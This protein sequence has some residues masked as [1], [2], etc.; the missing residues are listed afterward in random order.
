MFDQVFIQVTSGNGGSGTISGRR[1]KF[2]PAGGPDGGDGGRGG[3]VYMTT[4]NNVTTLLEFR[5]RRRFVAGSGGHGAGALKH[6]EAGRDVTIV[7]PVGTEV[8]REGTRPRVLFD[9]ANPGQRVRVATGGEGGR[10]NAKF[11]SSTTRYPMLAE[12]GERGETIKLRLELKLLADVA[13]MGAPNAGKSSLLAAVSA[14]RPKI[15][16]YPFTTLE[17]FLGVV[18]H[19]GHRFV[20]VDV[21]GLI[22]GAHEGAGLGHDFLR[23]IERTRV[24]VHV[25]DGSAEDPAQQY[26]EIRR[27]VRAY[28]GSDAE[29]PGVVAVNKIDL[30][31][32]AERASG[33]KSDL[34]T[35]G[36]EVCFISAI[37][38]EGVGPL[39]DRV[40]SILERTASSGNGAG[41][42]DGQ[43]PVLRPK[44]LRNPVKVVRRHEAFVV[45]MP[46]A[47]RMAAMVDTNNWPAMTQFYGHLERI[48]VIKALERA[49][50]ASGDKVR[51]GKVEW[52]WE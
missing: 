36:E 26:R 2:V 4:D 42:G 30:P 14:A 23:H 38:G 46:S 43:L 51:I 27:E 16:A 3:S 20:M 28:R 45:E 37:T 12:E 9:L 48:G 11:A 33:L 50:I 47:A 15:G 21:P 18:E 41:A 31:E 52:E 19:R 49:G 40:A 5:Y 34:A 6:G 13:L 25:V 35:V 29:K 24:W 1:E 22:E 32:V 39:M 17:P 7:V 44:S 10:G 8:W